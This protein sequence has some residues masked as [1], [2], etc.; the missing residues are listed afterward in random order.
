MGV[1]EMK[2]YNWKPLKDE[3]LATIKLDGV[4][5]VI[6]DGVASSRA[7]KPLYNVPK[8][9]DGTYECFI[10]D[11]NTTVSRLRTK[12]GELIPVEKFFQLEPILERGLWL[13][14]VS[15][16]QEVRKTFNETVANGFEGLVLHGSNNQ[17][18]KVK[19]FK[20]S[21]L[22]VRNI[23]PGK[24][25]HKGRMGALMTSKGKVGTGF[26]DIERE[27]NWKIGETIE[28][29]FMGLTKEGKMRHP[30]FKRRRFDK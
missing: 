9:F 7:G 3:W 19:P 1:N 15:T 25:K 12:D 14:M 28:V 4:Q 8:L 29:E 2:S 17:M 18:M 21:D 22:K 16:P 5:V 30:R 6:K 11:W 13:R 27:L 23:V 24:G 20:T 10:D 26:T